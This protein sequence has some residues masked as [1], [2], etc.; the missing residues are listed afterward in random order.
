[1]RQPLHEVGRR[2]YLS[3]WFEVGDDDYSGWEDIEDSIAPTSAWRKRFKERLDHTVEIDIWRKIVQSDH[4]RAIEVLRQ[5]VMAIGYYA[6]GE[7]TW[8]GSG[9]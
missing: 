6:A 1:M 8:C 7:A 2:A 4:K 3:H 9:C 5:I